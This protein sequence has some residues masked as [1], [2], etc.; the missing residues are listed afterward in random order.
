MQ[1]IQWKAWR[2]EKE[3]IYTTGTMTVVYIIDRI[4]GEGYIYRKSSI[5]IIKPEVNRHHI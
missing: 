3:E 2:E 4:N 1:D 5:F